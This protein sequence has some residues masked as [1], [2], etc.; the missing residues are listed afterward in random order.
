MD[1]LLFKHAYFPRCPS[2]V[3]V[4][5]YEVMEPLHQTR[6]QLEDTVKEVTSQLAD[7]E[8]EMMALEEVARVSCVRLLVLWNYG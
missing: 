3:Q 7:R 8:Q 4:R 5:M 6:V 1:T 2:H